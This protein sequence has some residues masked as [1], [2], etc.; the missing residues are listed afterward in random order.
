L[1]SHHD[2]RQVI[3]P[4]HAVIQ[5]RAGEELTARRVIHAI[6]A[7]RLAYPLHDTAMDLAFDDQ[8]VEY[9]ADIVDCGVGDESQLAGIRIDLDLGG[10]TSFAWLACIT[11][12]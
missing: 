9:H 7:Q 8:R 6:L 1:R 2:L 12:V 5:K 11:S 3:R 10:G 4:R